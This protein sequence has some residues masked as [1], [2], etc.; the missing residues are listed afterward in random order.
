[1]SPKSAAYRRAGRGR[2]WQRAYW[3]SGTSDDI[4]DHLASVLGDLAG[5]TPD[6]D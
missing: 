4:R 1:M 2:S 6:G 5:W 3:L